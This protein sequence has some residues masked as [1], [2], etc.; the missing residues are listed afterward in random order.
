MENY[1]QEALARYI[2]H[3]IKS[4]GIDM[5][6]PDAR[7]EADREARRLQGE[8]WSLAIIAADNDPG[9]SKTH[10]YIRSL[11]DM[12]D[13]YASRQAAL[14]KHLP[15][16]VL[17]LL[18]LMLL[19]A[20]TVLGYAGGIALSRPKVATVSLSVLIVLV[21][22][23]VFD[24]DRPRRGFVQVSQASMLELEELIP[25]HRSK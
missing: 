21:L 23:L 22:F 17:Y 10:L 19:I 18:F 14:N 5:A 1:A 15:A 9:L 25:K 20:E 8:I 2:E 13:S 3:R 4:V 11:N 12:I 6:Q 16:I 24:L 7:R